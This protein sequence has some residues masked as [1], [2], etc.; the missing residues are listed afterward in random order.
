MDIEHWPA[1][2]VHL[3]VDVWIILQNL[4]SFRILRAV[5]TKSLVSFN[6]SRTHLKVLET[7]KD[8]L[9]GGGEGT[10]GSTYSFEHV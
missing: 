3:V 10:F 5:A 6:L 4:F 1:L 9:P 8:P 2:L 7:F